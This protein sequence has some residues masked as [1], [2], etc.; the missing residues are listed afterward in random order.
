MGSIPG[1]SAMFYEHYGD[2]KELGTLLFLDVEGA[3]YSKNTG[4]VTT[5]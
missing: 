2:F 4:K 3:G 1:G 5:I